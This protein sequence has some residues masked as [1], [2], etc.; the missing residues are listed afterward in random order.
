MNYLSQFYK[1]DFD[2]DKLH[3]LCTEIVWRF[4]KWF[5]SQHHCLIQLI[6][7]K[8]LYLEKICSHLLYSW[9][10]QIIMMMQFIEPSTLVYEGPSF[11]SEEGGSKCDGH[12]FL[13]WK[14]GGVNY[15]FHNCEMEGV[16]N[17]VI[18]SDISIKM[19]GVQFFQPGKIAVFGLW[20]FVNLGPTP[21]HR[22]MVSLTKTTTL[23]RDTHVGHAVELQL[24]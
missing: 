18:K 7:Y 1:V 15:T 14:I 5:A 20:Q 21:F 12:K 13:S 3:I 10:M 24:K 2:Q 19:R 17:K 8:P 9:M 4:K 23:S 6:G 11:P 22:M 16:G